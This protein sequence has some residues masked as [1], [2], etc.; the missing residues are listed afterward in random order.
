MADQVNQ[1]S[2]ELNEILKNN[3]MGTEIAKKI[4][5]KDYYKEVQLSKD[6]ELIKNRILAVCNEMNNRNS[7]IKSVEIEAILV[8]AQ[9]QFNERKLNAAKAVEKK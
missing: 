5:E 4:I 6:F 9:S 1:L 3:P 8:V 2:H 7:L